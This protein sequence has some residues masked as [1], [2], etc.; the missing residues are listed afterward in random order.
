MNIMGPPSAS[1]EVVQRKLREQNRGS[2]FTDLMVPALYEEGLRWGVDPVV[3]IAQSAK[4]TA[5]GTFPGKVKGWFNNPAGIKVHPMEQALLAEVSKEPTRGESSLDHA[6]FA[7]W[8][9][10][11][12]AQAQHLRRYAGMPVPD[13]EV[14]YQRHWV[15]QLFRLKTVFDL[16]GRWAPSPSYG[17]EIVDIARTL[18][19]VG[20]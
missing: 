12:R 17:S 11:A 20:L 16:S 6:R 2:V 9:Q 1:L 15:V 4:E 10:G 7:N 14:V 8:T 3:M 13:N 18:I 5:W 19:E